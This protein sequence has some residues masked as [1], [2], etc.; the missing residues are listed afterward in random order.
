MLS[1]IM[2]DGQLL[3]QQAASTDGPGLVRDVTQ[4]TAHKV[5]I[6]IEYYMTTVYVPSSEL[7]LSHLLSRQRVCPPPPPNQRGGGAHSPAVEGVGGSQ[8]QLSTLHTLWYSPR[9]IKT[10]FEYHSSS[11]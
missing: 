5:H 7:G 1:G 8:F 2:D 9:L 3:I 6:F 11:K 4:S 10:I